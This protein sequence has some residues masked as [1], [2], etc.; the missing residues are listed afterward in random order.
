MLAAPLE[1]WRQEI[2][3]TGPQGVVLLRLQPGDPA[4]AD[5][6]HRDILRPDLEDRDFQLQFQRAQA[7]SVTYT[8]DEGRLSFVLLNTRQTPPDDEPY[9]IAH[10][11]GHLWLKALKYPAPAYAGGPAACLS[12]LTGDAVQH[13]LIRKDMDRRGIEWRAPWIR[14]LEPALKAMEAQRNPPPPTRCQAMTQT[15]L[16]I[17]VSLGLTDEQWPERRRF[18]DLLTR[19]FPVIEPVAPGLAAYLEKQNLVPRDG[20]VQALQTVFNRLKEMTLP[21]AGDTPAPLPTR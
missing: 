2:E 17:D 10:E 6:P 16:W 4:P 1:L 19:Q 3:K 14:T 18:L 13:V 5:T 8:G 21:L 15:I 12:I 9:V 20:H 7:L 11:F